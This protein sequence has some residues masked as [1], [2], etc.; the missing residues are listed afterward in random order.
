[1]IYSIVESVAGDYQNN[2][3]GF[4]FVTFDLYGTIINDRVSADVNRLHK[5]AAKAQAEM[6]EFLDG[7]DV[8]AHY[9]RVMAEHADR[10][11][12]QA[13]NLH[14]LAKSIKV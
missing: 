5:T 13:V 3:R 14:K 12:A 10:I 2:S 11:K 4:R 8:A 9:K 6:W 1:M 7:L